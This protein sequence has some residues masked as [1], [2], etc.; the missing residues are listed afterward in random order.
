MEL[1]NAT[2]MVAGYTMSLEPSGRESLVVVIKGTF[3]LPKTGEAVRLHDEQ[4]PLV[5]ADTFTG[6][7]GFS[8]PVYEVDF[9]P[10]KRACDVL[11]LGSAHAL[12]ARPV[13]CVE[14]GLR[15]GP[16]VKHFNVVG[17]RV[18]HAGLTGI[19]ATPPKPFV[20]MPI[21]YDVAF[22][23]ADQE[24]EDPSEHDAYLANPVGRGFRKHLKNAWVDG[25]PLP[26]TEQAGE[27][28]T[29]PTGRYQ[30]M[31][32]GPVGRG[33][34]GRSE[35]AGTYDQAWLDDLFPF[36]PQDFDERY[37]QAAPADQQVPIATAPMEVALTNLTTDGLRHFVL[38]HFDAPVHVFPKRG[39]R[40][41]LTAMLDTIVFEPDHERFTMSWRVTRPLMKNMLEIAQVLV[42]RKGREWW[43]QRG[44]VKFPIPVV[45][46]PMQ[47]EAQEAAKS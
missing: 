27:A 35:Y 5:M 34:A 20:Q 9:A 44:K 41:N 24:S 17:D 28:V 42:G 46:A 33:W 39:Q 6:E 18:W 10:R 21:S 31:A 16:M 13:T 7:P 25:K 2:R 14:V 22:G 19:R 32:F 38:P 11:L 1:I 37:F 43:Q 4:L 12:G 3:V 30:P 40:E 23:G 8:A 26:N 15:V 47:R 45:T 29:W 36:L